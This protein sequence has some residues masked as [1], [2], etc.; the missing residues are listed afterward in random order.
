MKVCGF[1]GE[2]RQRNNKTIEVAQFPLLNVDVNVFW[3][4]PQPC[5]V[6]KLDPANYR[7]YVVENLRNEDL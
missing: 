6:K 1:P 5:F 7:R 4:C 3:S 2:K